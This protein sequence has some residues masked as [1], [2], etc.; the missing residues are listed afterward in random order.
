MRP[1]R[2]RQGAGFAKRLLAIRLDVWAQIC[3]VPM[4]REI[5]SRIL[6]GIDTRDK[7]ECEFGTERAQ[8]DQRLLFPLSSFAVALSSTTLLLPATN[9]VFALLPLFSIDTRP[10]RMEK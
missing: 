1:G 8:P 5:I 2:K 6:R 4:W 10:W 9:G 3:Y 7:D